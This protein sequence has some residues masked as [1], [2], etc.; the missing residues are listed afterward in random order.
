MKIR[1]AVESDIPFIV[2][3][4]L[5][6]EKSGDSNTY[7]NLFSTDTATTKNYLRNILKDE[8]N[9]DTELSLNTFYVVEIEHNVVGCCSHIYTSKQY[10]V[11][12]G[13]TFSF[14]LDPNHLTNF[15]NNA[16]DLPSQEIS[17]DKHF[18]EY[19]LIAEE[20]R[21]KGLVGKLMQYVIDEIKINPL[22]INIFSNNDVACKAYEK[23]GFQKYLEVDLDTSENKI[24]P[25]LTKIIMI[26]ED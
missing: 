15:V 23:L 13:E 2:D 26:K 3:A 11:N 10:Y 5:E 1:K 22:Y 14:H 12:K 21:G 24:Y 18:I 16:K 6:I 9:L 20:Q 8:E 25:S 4:I 7:N 17:H 19:V